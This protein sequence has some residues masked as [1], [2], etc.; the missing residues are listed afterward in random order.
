MSGNVKSVVVIGIGNILF[1]DE[2]VGVYASRYLD[3]NYVFKPSID[4]IDGGTLGFKL[5]AYYQGYDRVILLDTV[6]IDDKP[7]SVYHLPAEA[8]IG[9]GSYRQTAHEVE[10]V[11]MLEICMLLDKMAEMSVVGIVPEDIKS[12]EIDLTST[13]YHHF[14]AIIERTLMELQKVGILATLNDNHKTLAEIIYAYNNPTMATI[15]ERT[16]P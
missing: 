14:P 2:G 13:L 3:E 16:T 15:M 9:L 7:G 10:V 11:E 1:K 5:M 12:V 6:S 8:L 4:I